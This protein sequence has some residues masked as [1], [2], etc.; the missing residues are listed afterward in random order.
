MKFFTTKYNSLRAKCTNP[1]CLRR[2]FRHSF[3]I[4]LNS[5]HMATAKCAIPIRTHNEVLP[6]P[7]CGLP[8]YGYG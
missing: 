5:M 4:F 6:L 1:L 3:A 2:L 8:N 7:E